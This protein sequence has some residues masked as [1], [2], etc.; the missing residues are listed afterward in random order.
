[1]QDALKEIFRPMFG[2]CIIKCISRKTYIVDLF[3]AKYLYIDSNIIYYI[4]KYE[5]PKSKL[6]IIS[7]T[8]EPSI[9]QG[10]LPNRNVITHTCKKAKYIN[11]FDTILTE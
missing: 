5:L 9:Y 7:A 2:E 6:I 1:M 4:K 10:F 8:A 11:S 3:Q